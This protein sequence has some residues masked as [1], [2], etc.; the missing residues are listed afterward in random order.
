MSSFLITRRK[1]TFLMFTSTDSSR[2]RNSSLFE[3]KNHNKKMCQHLIKFAYIKIFKMRHKLPWIVKTVLV[4]GDEVEDGHDSG[5]PAD[6]D[7]SNPGGDGVIRVLWVQRLLHNH[8]DAL[9]HSSMDTKLKHLL[10]PE[11]DLWW[12]PRIRWWGCQQRA[13]DIFT[14]SVSYWSRKTKC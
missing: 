10:K 12:R 14:T 8:V 2:K 11:E 5:N 6:E 7:D 3:M 4:A 9:E 1:Q 13:P